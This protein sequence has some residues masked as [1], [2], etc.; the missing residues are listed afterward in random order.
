MNDRESLQTMLDDMRGQEKGFDKYNAD[1]HLPM[2]AH[3]VFFLPVAQ[4]YTQ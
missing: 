2:L 4:L 3:Q 1:C